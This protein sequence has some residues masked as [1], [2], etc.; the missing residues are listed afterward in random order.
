VR[1]ALAV[2]LAV[3]VT[4]AFLAACTGLALGARSPLSIFGGLAALSYLGLR[5]L[6]LASELL[7]SGGTKP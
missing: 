2:L 7:L 3:V 1:R 4:V 5:G 6:A